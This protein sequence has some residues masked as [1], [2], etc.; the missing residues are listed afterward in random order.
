MA[1][2]VWARC[3][4]TAGALCE[5]EVQ[6]VDLTEASIRVE[7]LVPR[8]AEAADDSPVRTRGVTLKRH[9]VPISNVDNTWAVVYACR[10]FTDE[11]ALANLAIYSE[12]IPG[13]VLSR[14]VDLPVAADLARVGADSGE[15]SESGNDAR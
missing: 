14:F 15:A 5:L 6:V 4:C 10:P 8:S 7:H 2:H 3:A 12:V 1:D 11:E 9:V 13:E